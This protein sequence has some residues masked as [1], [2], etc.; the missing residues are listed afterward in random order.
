[1]LNLLLFQH[2]INNNNNHYKI[3]V[4]HIHACISWT[5]ND[6]YIDL[7]MY[8]LFSIRSSDTKRI[9]FLIIRGI[10]A[11]VPPTDNNYTRVYNNVITRKYYD[12]N[13]I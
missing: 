3:N 4:F 2:R 8:N 13:N 6:M 1:M 12:Y 7:S 9:E 10:L 5:A 11:Q